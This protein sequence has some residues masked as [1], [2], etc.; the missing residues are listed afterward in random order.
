VPSIEIRRIV[1][2]IVSGLA[3]GAAFAAVM[4]LDIALSGEPVDDFRL[5][6]AFGP[7]RGKWRIVGPAIH[8]ANSASLG[9]LFALTSDRLRGPGWRRGLTFALIENTV[10]WPV[11]I[12]LDRV[13]PAIRSGDLPPYN[14]LWP[15]IAEN[16]RHAAFG[17]ALGAV[18][19]RLE[20]RRVP[21]ARR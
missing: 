12:V 4:K 18:Y 21:D 7:L 3:G 20:R 16:V 10:L 15:F 11:I 2:G 13:H 17:I 9:A 8:A 1:P 6:A 5:L 19:E 14:R